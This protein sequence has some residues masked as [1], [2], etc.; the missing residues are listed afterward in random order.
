MIIVPSDVLLYRLNTLF[1]GIITLH[2]SSFEGDLN[3]SD[4]NLSKI[5]QI[6]T[7]LAHP[8]KLAF[9]DMNASIFTAFYDFFNQC[10][11]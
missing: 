4:Y 3:S 2:G 1:Q 7:Y 6:V 11:T 10:Y 5:A 9:K 8:Y